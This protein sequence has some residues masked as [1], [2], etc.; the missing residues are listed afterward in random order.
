MNSDA[1]TPAAASILALAPL[2]I[3]IVWLFSL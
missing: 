3:V 1:N 2:M